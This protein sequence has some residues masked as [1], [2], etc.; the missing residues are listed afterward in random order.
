MTPHLR[1]LL[2]LVPWIMLV[3]PNALK[4]VQKALESRS[5]LRFAS[6]MRNCSRSDPMN[7][8]QSLESP[9]I[10]TIRSQLINSSQKWILSSMIR[11][12][13]ALRPHFLHRRVKRWT[14][15]R[16]GC[17]SSPDTLHPRAGRKVSR[18]HWRKHQLGSG[19]HEVSSH[20]LTEKFAAFRV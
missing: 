11:F 6:R 14:D 18:L 15:H 1:I 12:P 16:L 2:F 3:A 5:Y 9:D 4:R 20:Q 7:Q 8:V 19:C 13:T 17:R 10:H